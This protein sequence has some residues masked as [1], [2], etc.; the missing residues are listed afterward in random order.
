MNLYDLTIIKHNGGCYIDS[1]EVAEIIDK[2]HRHLLRDIRGYAKYIEN[3]NAPNFGLVDFFLESTYIDGKGETRPCF[4]LSKMGCEMVATKLTGE[5]GIL[6]SAAYVA[7]F[8]ELEKAE[9]SIQEAAQSTPSTPRLG[10]YN[11]AARIL[12]RALQNMGA[13][14]ER[15]LIFLKE[16]YEPLGISVSEDDEF[17][18]IPRLYNLRQIAKM[19][20]I[21]S[22]NG[23]PHAMAVG[24]ILNENLFLDEN[25]KTVITAN[26]GDNIHVSVR[27][28]EEAVSA[29]ADWI[30]ENNFPSEI[31]GFDRTFKILYRTG[32]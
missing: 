16:L 1:R 32:Y 19:L 28:S 14:S 6:F 22:I 20:G 23:N 17:D 18:N 30:V 10:E 7:K 26:Y 3:F 9:R 25:Y 11:A 29:A 24:C 13:T 31:Y 27:Y 21:Y 5:K 8:N 12:V 2:P 4:L 15:I